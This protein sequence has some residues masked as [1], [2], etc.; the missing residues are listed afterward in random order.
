MEPPGEL[1]SRPAARTRPSPGRGRL[2]WA[3]FPSP[4]IVSVHVQAQKLSISLVPV[5]DVW[6]CPIVSH[7][8]SYRTPGG[9][10]GEYHLLWV[11]ASTRRLVLERAVRG[12]RPG[13]HLAHPHSAGPLSRL[14]GGP[15]DSQMHA[16]SRG[17]PSPSHPTTTTTPSIALPRHR[18]SGPTSATR[19][20]PRPAQP[21]PDQHRL[22]TCE[23][24]FPDWILPTF[25]ENTTSRSA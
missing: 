2:V 19:D 8:S 3:L 5:D 7:L 9:F 10:G 21:A 25:P 24:D 6:I 11:V 22:C 15:W 17:R 13:V 14:G 4:G 1:Q 20:G 12:G 23:L 16:F 18:C